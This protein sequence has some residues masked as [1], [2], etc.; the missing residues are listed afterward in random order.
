MRPVLTLTALIL[1]AANAQAQ[2]TG[3]TALAA[4]NKSSELNKDTQAVYAANV[5]YHDATC[6][7][8]EDL[9]DRYDNV[10]CFMNQ[11]DLDACGMLMSSA[12]GKNGIDGSKG[13]MDK[14]K[15]HGESGD[16]HYYAACGWFLIGYW[17]D[18][19]NSCASADSNNNISQAYGV[20]SVVMCAAARAHM[21]TVDAIIKKYE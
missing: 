10:A 13:K 20:D 2:A 5:S 4:C 6:K 9:C 1:F 11:E 21:E 18:C 19:E 15:T 17:Q 3:E 12:K 7:I 14:S 8:H 16:S